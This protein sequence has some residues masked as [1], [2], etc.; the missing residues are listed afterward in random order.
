MSKMT[1]IK[2]ATYDVI[3]IL[4]E[5]DVEYLIDYICGDIYITIDNT[6]YS[7]RATKFRDKVRLQVSNHY[8]SFGE[9]EHTY[10]EDLTEFDKWIEAQPWGHKH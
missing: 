3:C 4:Q 1:N 6:G 10:Y 8:A 2:E 7:I 9:D 5:R